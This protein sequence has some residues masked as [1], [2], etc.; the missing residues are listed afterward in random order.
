MQHP[1]MLRDTAG[2]KEKCNPSHSPKF[3]SIP[4]VFY[5]TVLMRK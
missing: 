5:R 4:T 1:V 2:E 3:M